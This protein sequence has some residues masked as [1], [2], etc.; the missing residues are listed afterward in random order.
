MKE[1][2]FIRLLFENNH[3]PLNY[4]HTSI[5][6]LVTVIQESLSCC[7]NTRRLL[8]RS[9]LNS[10]FKLNRAKIQKVLWNSLHSKFRQ[11]LILSWLPQWNVW[12]SRYVFIW[13][14]KWN[15]HWNENMICVRK[16]LSVRNWH[17]WKWLPSRWRLHHVRRRCVWIRLV[18]KRNANFWRIG[19]VW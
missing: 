15:R 3:F 12:I 11:N 5:S 13:N 4:L 18:W 17:F 2:R 10:K 16:Q 1:V 7:L 19:R 8:I 6:I 14:R 9:G